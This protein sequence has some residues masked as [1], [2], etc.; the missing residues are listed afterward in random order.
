MLV[1]AKRALMRASSTRT[2]SRAP[3][4]RLW[5]VSTSTRVASPAHA[6]TRSAVA[7]YTR[8]AP[9]APAAA[10]AVYG[11]GEGRRG[12]APGPRVGGVSVR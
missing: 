4:S 9:R 3:N 11:F 12:W 5:L 8:R 7:R 6:A 2:G 10:A 1:P